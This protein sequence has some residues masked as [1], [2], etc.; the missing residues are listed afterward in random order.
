MIKKRYEAIKKLLQD[1]GITYLD[2]ESYMSV[3]D[4][5]TEYVEYAKRQTAFSEKLVEAYQD[6]FN[7]VAQPVL[8][9]DIGDT[10]DTYFNYFDVNWQTGKIIAVFDGLQ[11]KEYDAEALVEAESKIVVKDVLNQE[12]K[13]GCSGSW[14]GISYAGETVAN[15]IGEANIS[16]DSDMGELNSALIECNIAPIDVLKQA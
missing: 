11:L 7:G 3:Q 10:L 6:L 9:H 16:P 15:F 14:G 5:N 8:E 4:G 1:A 2:A 13:D 12:L